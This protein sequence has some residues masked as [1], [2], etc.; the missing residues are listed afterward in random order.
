MI[1]LDVWTAS[2]QAKRGQANPSRDRKEDQKN[3]VRNVDGR[4]D[5]I[6]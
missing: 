3:Q 6:H 1:G 4:I 5:G 2:V